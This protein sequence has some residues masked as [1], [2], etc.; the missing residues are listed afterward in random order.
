[1]HLRFINTHFTTQ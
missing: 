1:M